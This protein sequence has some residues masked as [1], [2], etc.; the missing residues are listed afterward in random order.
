MAKPIHSSLP[1][2]YIPRH[3]RRNCLL[4]IRQSTPSE[5]STSDCNRCCL[6]LPWMNPWTRWLIE[7]H[8]FCR[9]AASHWMSETSR[10]SKNW[11]G[12]K[13][14]KCLSFIR[15]E[16]SE[17]FPRGWSF[18]CSKLGY[19]TVGEWCNSWKVWETEMK[20]AESSSDMMVMRIVGG[21]LDDLHRNT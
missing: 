5:S 15:D 13:A 2:G 18:F 14:V 21:G 4:C 8:G 16:S 3:T 20:C 17:N 7:V 11:N 9:G 1:L 10:C 12:T 19:D 6:S